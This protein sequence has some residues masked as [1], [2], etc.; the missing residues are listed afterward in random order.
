MMLDRDLMDQGKEQIYGTQGTCR[1]L[2]NGVQEC[3]I[4]PIQEPKK[5]NA[6]RKNAGFEMT[7]EDNAKRLGIEYRVVK[8]KEVK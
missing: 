5:V 1:Q 8:L 6:R 3:F 7:V 4:W 2:K